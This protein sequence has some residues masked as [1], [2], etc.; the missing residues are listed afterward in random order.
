MRLLRLP[1][2]IA[3]L[4]VMLSAS[5]AMAAGENISPAGVSLP[6]AAVTAI[7]SIIAGGLSGAI[8]VRVSLALYGYRL[9]ILE[10]TTKE[11]T[12]KFED[13]RD[14]M[15]KVRVNCAENHP[16]RAASVRT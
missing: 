2:P 16:R 10:T 1:V 7:S 14:K 6:W 8:G 5:I 13:V 4:L 11:H 3:A 15:E 12:D 9:T